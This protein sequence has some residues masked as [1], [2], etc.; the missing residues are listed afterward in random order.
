MA[1][2]VMGPINALVVGGWSVKGAAAVIRVITGTAGTTRL[3]AN[4]TINQ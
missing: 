4:T 1:K 2:N 3:V